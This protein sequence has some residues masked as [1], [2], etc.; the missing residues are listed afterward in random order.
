MPSPTLEEIT[1]LLARTPAALNALLRD[2]SEVWTSRSEGE[3]T[4]TP[5]GVVGHL[6]HGEHT[7]WMPRVH[8]ILEHGE[9][10]TFVPFDREAQN[11]ESVGR[12]LPE[13]LD[14][15]AAARAHNLNS[16]CTLNLT[17]EDLERRGRHPRLGVVTLGNL[18]STW[19]AHDLTHLHQLARILA[20]Q[21][22]EE[23]GPWTAFLGVL[24]CTGHSEP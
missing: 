7:D 18:L 6:L 1:A 17:P 19:G 10:Q 3:G 11:R 24:R 2:L 15:F 23:V 21:L 12:T 5:F 4:W 8:M 9:A 22:R 20:H 13:L 16:L 14:A